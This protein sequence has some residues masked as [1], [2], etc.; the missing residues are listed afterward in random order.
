[1]FLCSLPDVR[2]RPPIGNGHVATNVLSDTVYMNG[3]FNGREDYSSRARIPAY[4]S[5]DVNT[6]SQKSV[7]RSYALDMY[8]GKG[9]V[10]KKCP[11]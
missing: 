5:V 3:V 7:T 10:D 1:M 4:I 11:K 9:N 2:F 8:N 6:T